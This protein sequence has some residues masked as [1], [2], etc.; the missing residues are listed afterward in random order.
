LYF[1][2]ML[3]ENLSNYTYLYRVLFF[4]SLCEFLSSNLRNNLLHLVKLENRVIYR[5]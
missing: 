5:T 4:V 2:Q 3:L 1:S